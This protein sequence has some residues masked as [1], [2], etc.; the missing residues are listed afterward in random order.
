MFATTGEPVFTTT[1]PM[2]DG[3]VRLSTTG[4]PP[5]APF[6]KHFFVGGNVYV[7]NILRAFGAERQMTAS[8]EHLE[9]TVERVT[10]QL[11]NRTASVEIEGVELSNARLKAIVSVRSLV[12]HKFPTGFP[13]RRAWLC[14]TVQDAHGRIVFESGAVNPDGSI[15]GNDN[16][17]DPARYESHYQTIVSPDQVQIYEAIM[18][19]TEGEVTTGLLRAAAYVKDNRL[20]PSGFER[21]MASDDIAVYGEAVKDEDFLGGGDRVEYNVELE[22]AQGPFVVAVELLYQS[23]SYRWAQNL[24]RHDAPETVRFLDYYEA[25]PNLPVVAASATVEVEDG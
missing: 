3:A 4:G 8:G 15:I 21:S 24:G 11:Q 19:N 6:A 22:D 12:G 14:L 25:V 20:L 2:A 10:E 23:V 9:A 17:T 18:Q 7:L 16:D 13:A 5:R 1:I